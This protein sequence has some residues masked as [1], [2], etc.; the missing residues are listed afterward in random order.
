MSD[1]TT[2]EPQ[3]R[4]RARPREDARRPPA[5]HVI[6]ENDDHHS[7]DFVIAVLRKVFGVTEQRA[8]EFALEAHKTGRCI[9][10]TG[11]KEVAELKVEQI[12]S[13]SEI[14]ADGAKLGPLG[15]CIEPAA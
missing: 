3:V 12:H 1:S 15:A 11:S 7:F 13:C 14:R 10:W 8:L 2:A 5:Y 9:V 4:P 6:L